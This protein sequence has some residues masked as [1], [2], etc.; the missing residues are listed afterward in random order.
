MA[1]GERGGSFVGSVV[2]AL[3]LAGCT[4][5]GAT[6]VPNDAD[7]ARPGDVDPTL[8]GYIHVQ[9]VDIE[10]VPIEGASVF[11]MPGNHVGTTSINGTV[12]IGPLE[13]GEYVVAIEKAGYRGDEK[14]V[15]LTEDIATR[16]T[17]T[18]TPV[19]TN[20]PYFETQIRVTFIQCGIGSSIPELGSANIPCTVMNL[21]YQTGQNITQ[22]SDVFLLQITQPNLANLL[23]ET[24]WV[25][26]LYAHD[27]LFAIV[28][29]GQ[30]N[31]AVSAGGVA[32][33]EYRVRN[34]GGPPLTTWVTPG[35]VNPGGSV[36]FDGN[37]SAE[38]DAVARGVARN[39]TL[40]YFALYLDHRVN[41]FV[42]FFYNRPGQ[43]A[44][45]ALPDK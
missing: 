11:V 30:V 27:M 2:V 19:A 44:F 3:I 35:V 32:S 10:I 42:T 45:S 25:P 16:L 13:P 39:S 26:R 29:K 20:V 15:F 8:P 37:V 38:Y 17:F 7:I 31:T 6:S 9:V 24:D 12:S 1:V 33:F 43:L 5:N 21:N 41:N 23:V 36:P 40:Q 4:S 28:G 22:D 14:S 18:I 34:S